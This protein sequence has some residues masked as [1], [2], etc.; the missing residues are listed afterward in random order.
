M[1]ERR[2]KPKR[3]C[4]SLFWP[5]LLISLGLV[6][7]LGNLGMIGVQNI[8]ALL[9]MWPLLLI[10]VGL[11]L[12]VGRRSAFIGALIGLGAVALAGF[13]LLAG[14]SLGLAGEWEAKSF[15]RQIPLDG[16]ETAFVTLDLSVGES[17]LHSL[18]DSPN[19]ME[20]DIVYMGSEIVMNVSGE[21]KKNISLSPTTHLD[22]N[23]PFHFLGLLI[24]KDNTG[25]RWDIG[26]NPRVPIELDINGGLGNATIDL[27][28]IWLRSL[29]LDAGAGAFD[30]T[31]PA[32]EA[33][34]SA[35][36]KGGVG[37]LRI[38][39]VEGADLTLRLEGGAGTVTI[40]VPDEAAVHIDVT[41]GL[42][43]VTM[44]RHFQKVREGDL[45]GG[46][47]ETEGFGG[48]DRQIDILFRGALGTLTVE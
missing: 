21:A 43:T 29:Y 33:A 30:L 7:L 2:D 15:N 44:P 16:T 48:A 1:S 42:T 4:R 6:F 3:G 18:T 31:L 13:I 8:M 25:P 12:L 10:L 27:Q 26:L 19:L 41:G 11:D 5:V 14:P 20:T 9:R 32:T 45:Q 36:I 38:T 17:H 35:E 28:D 46:T 47:W 39:I 23:G 22:F 37:A 40:D 34:Y 24:D